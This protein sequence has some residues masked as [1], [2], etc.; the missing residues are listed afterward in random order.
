[1]Y[2]KAYDHNTKMVIDATWMGFPR[3][4]LCSC[5]GDP[6]VTC[7]GQKLSYQCGISATVVMDGKKFCWSHSRMLQKGK[8]PKFFPPVNQ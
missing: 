4:D 6:V 7:K 2:R 3:G 1:M 8:T 5:S